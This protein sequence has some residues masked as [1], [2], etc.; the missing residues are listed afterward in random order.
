MSKKLTWWKAITP[1]H[2]RWQHRTFCKCDEEKRRSRKGVGHRPPDSRDETRRHK[3]FN[4]TPILSEVVVLVQ[5]ES[6]HSAAVKTG[7]CLYYRQ[8]LLS[9]TQFPRFGLTTSGSLVWVDHPAS[10]NR[11]RVWTPRGR[12]AGYAGSG[13]RRAPVPATC[14]AADAATP[15]SADQASNPATARSTGVAESTARNVTMTNGLLCANEV[16]LLWYI[17][18]LYYKS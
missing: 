7:V 4:F 13:V 1:A 15:S 10:A 18:E 11:T 2:G 12:R 3:Y 8:R 16:L 17:F 6:A 14:C 9:F 5:F